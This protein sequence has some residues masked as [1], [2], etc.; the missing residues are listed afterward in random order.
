[1]ASGSLWRGIT[2]AVCR[3]QQLIAPL[4]AQG[5]MPAGRSNPGSPKVQKSQFRS[6]ALLVMCPALAILQ[7]GPGGDAV[8]YEAVLNCYTV[9]S[10]HH[11]P[12]RMGSTA[13][14]TCAV[15]QLCCLSRPCMRRPPL[16]LRHP[17]LRSLLASYRIGRRC[18][19]TL[20]T[21]TTRPPRS[22]ST[23]PRYL[24]ASPAHSAT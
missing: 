23:S 19:W 16:S 3:W 21:S 15:R 6:S 9:Y 20:G 1:M 12:D 11:E 17:F 4:P 7:E 8:E 24:S 22:R 5:N 18:P 14:Q 2:W 10:R 13:T